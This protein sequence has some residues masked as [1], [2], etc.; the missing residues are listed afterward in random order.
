M[1]YLE[2]PLDRDLLITQAGD[3]ALL[4]NRQLNL[5]L[6]AYDFFV[7]RFPADTPSQQLELKDVQ[8]SLHAL[9]SLPHAIAVRL[10]AW[11]KRIQ[12]TISTEGFEIHIIN[13]FALHVHSLALFMV[14]KEIDVEPFDPV[15]FGDAVKTLRDTNRLLGKPVSTL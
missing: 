10:D 9:G 15:V 14:R 8:V 11:K 6:D 2:H 7:Q 4:F 13:E 12:P 3:I 1:T 5:L